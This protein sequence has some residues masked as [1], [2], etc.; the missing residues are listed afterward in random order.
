MQTGNPG[1]AG[2]WREGATG[3]RL[4]TAAPLILVALLAG[5]TFWLERMVQPV[6]RVGDKVTRHEPDYIV[7]KLS[8]VSM[9][10]KGTAAYTLSAERMMHYPDDDTTVLA[11]PRIVSY[12]AAKSPVTITASEAVV[13]ANGEHV[14]FQDDVRVTRAAHGN[15]S[16]LLVRTDFLHVIPD[17]N[18]ARTDRSVTITDAATTVTAVGFELNNET[19]VMKL[20]SRVQGTYDPAKSTRR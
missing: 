13:S 16:E 14:Y 12:G 3:D 2:R 4:T 20:H 1:G 11:A 19:H 17:Q 9:N 10:E 18:I 5:L 15:Y 6:A 7:E 8:A